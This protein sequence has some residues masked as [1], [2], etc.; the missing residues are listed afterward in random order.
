MRLYQPRCNRPAALSYAFACNTSLPLQCQSAALKKLSPEC[1]R[2]GGASKAI[3]I[4]VH[5]AASYCVRWTGS[6]SSVRILLSSAGR[7][8]R[9]DRRPSWGRAASA[10]VWGCSS[11]AGRAVYPRW[12]RDLGADSVAC[13]IP[14][15]MRPQTVRASGKRQLAR[16][17]P[18]RGG[19]RK[20]S[21]AES[22][23]PTPG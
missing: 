18:R 15:S 17:G 4:A 14:G 10:D 8:G 3:I 23:N 11:A 12:H 9:R 22:V 19:S 21:I 1:I 5:C 20:S 2:H 6:G 16:S 13:R 7:Q